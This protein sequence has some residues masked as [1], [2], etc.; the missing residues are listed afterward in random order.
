M[1]V[2]NHLQIGMKALQRHETA[3]LK[4]IVDEVI[5][6]QRENLNFKGSATTFR[7]K[8][9]EFGTIYFGGKKVFLDFLNNNRYTNAALGFVDS[10]IQENPEQVSEFLEEI[11]DEMGI[12]F[13]EVGFD[14]QTYANIIEAIKE[15][16]AVGRKGGTGVLIDTVM[17]NLEKIVAPLLEEEEPEDP[18]SMD[19]EQIAEAM[20]SLFGEQ[21]TTPQ[22][23]IRFMYSELE[24][25]PEGIRDAYKEDGFFGEKGVVKYMISTTLANGKDHIDKVLDEAKD[26]GLDLGL[27]AEIVAAS[28]EKGGVWGKAGLVETAA[29]AAAKEIPVTS[30]YLYAF[31]LTKVLEGRKEKMMKQLEGK[32]AIPKEQ[33]EKAI[34]KDISQK[35]AIFL[36]I[37]NV[38]EELDKEQLVDVI[39]KN[40]LLGEDGLLGY[41]RKNT[42]AIFKTA[43]DSEFIEDDEVKAF[44]EKLKDLAEMDS[45]KD[46]LKNI[47]TTGVA[48]N[49]ENFAAS[50]GYKAEELGIKPAELLSDPQYAD[51]MAQ[52]MTVAYGSI[53]K[54]YEEKVGQIGLV[55]P[56]IDKALK[57]M[58]ERDTSRENVT[59]VVKELLAR[60]KEDADEGIFAKA[61]EALI[62][63]FVKTTI[64]ER[65]RDYATLTQAF[66][67]K[68]AATN[69][70]ER[71][72]YIAQASPA[73]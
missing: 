55:P 17:D 29:I 34:E 13:S 40:G 9:V 51:T 30:Q 38:P 28:Y 2:E 18:M 60:V 43:L 24:I 26:D 42:Q 23:V 47:A 15:Q 25:T 59:K 1:G 48:T 61:G 66:A 37:S 33:L 20:V 3:R 39:G 10:Y 72:A 7:S 70:Q 46:I 27:S 67:E 73:E 22:G 57:A 41:L 63:R 62:T 16:G 71:E 52:L 50:V 12:K 19:P 36:R 54:A 65:I 32:I 35:A 21:K 44:E 8:L 69:K 31:M 11:E 68:Y 64:V 49:Y 45:A 53:K 6:E 56:A 58:D 4:T 14:R 5:S